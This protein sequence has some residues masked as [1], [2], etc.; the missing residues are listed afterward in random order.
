MLDKTSTAHA[1][2]DGLKSVIGGVFFDNIEDALAALNW[3]PDMSPKA[4]AERSAWQ[5]EAEMSPRQRMEAAAARR[6]KMGAA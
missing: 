3:L 4:Q 5:N 6:A 2:T 1:E